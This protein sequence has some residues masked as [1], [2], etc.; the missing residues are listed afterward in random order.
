MQR[1]LLMAS[2]FLSFAAATPVLA[3]SSLMGELPTSSRF[4]CLNCHTVQDPSMTEAALNVFG[5]AFK[6]NGA[7]WDAKL[8]NA[9]ADGDNCTNG[10]ELSDENGDGQLDSGRTEERAKPGEADCALQLKETTWQS[11]KTLFR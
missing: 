3:T 2:F 10:F 9:S 5:R 7:K 6:D 4:R 11:L 8:A 1:R